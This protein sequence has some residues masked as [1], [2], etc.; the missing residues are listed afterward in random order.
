MIRGHERRRP[1][2]VREPARHALRGPRD[3]R[4]LLA[5]AAHPHVAPAV[6]PPRARR[7]RRSGS[8]SRMR[9][10]RRSRPGVEHVDF[11]AAARYEARFR[12][13]VMAHVHCYGDVAPAA[14]GILHLGRDVLLRHRQR[15]TR[16][17]CARR[18]GSS[19]LALAETIAALAAFARR[20][21]DVPCLAYTHF[22]PAQPT[23]VG[24]RACLWLL[25]LRRRPRR[26]PA[27]GR[28]R[29]LP[30]LEGDDRHAGLVPLALRRRRRRRSRRSTSTS[31]GARASRPPCPSRARPTRA[32]PTGR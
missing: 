9:R 8:R 5:P 19:R 26:D 14:R 30:R 15:A 20:H 23:T 25:R 22:Q 28:R 21:R 13:D 31:R 29:A 7:S 2:R 11:E 6:D 27:R 16:S 3:A 18:S 1:R 12:H 4:A 24:K 10:S 32:A 17:S